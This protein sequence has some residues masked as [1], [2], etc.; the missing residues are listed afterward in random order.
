M[1][2]YIL[3][4]WRRLQMVLV[5]SLQVLKTLTT[6]HLIAC[7]VN[8][9]IVSWGLHY[10][11]KDI[12]FSNAFNRCWERLH[13]IIHT[14]TLKT[15]VNGARGKSSRCPVQSWRL[16]SHVIWSPA[17]LTF[18][19]CYRVF[20][21]FSIKV[22]YILSARAENGLLMLYEFHNEENICL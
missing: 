13:V 6:R 9:L 5:I 8:V 2:L 16:L 1:L 15:S 21:T 18:S 20:I 22:R 19:P 11:L 3:P 7:S 14:P 10:V 17:V 4:H 12:V